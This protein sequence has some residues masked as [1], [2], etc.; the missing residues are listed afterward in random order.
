M[1]KLGK[2]MVVLLFMMMI[3][4]VASGCSHL[5]LDD[6]KPM[7]SNDVVL[8]LPRG[9]TMTLKEI[10]AGS[11]MMG[12]P[13]GEDGRSESE[14]LHKVTLEH[15]FWL[16]EFEVTQA[17]YKAVM[18]IN[19]SIFKG[20]DYP[21]DNVTWLD[22][23][24]FCRKLTDMERAAGRLPEGYRYSLPSEAQWEYACRAGTTTAWHYG[25]SLSSKQANFEGD[26][27]EGQAAVG[28][29]LQRPARVGSYA[30][31]AWGL[32]DMHGNVWEWCRD[33]ITDE[34]PKDPEFP[35]VAMSSGLFA[36]IRGG[37]WNC[38]ADVCRSARCYNSI[39]VSRNFNIGFRVA[40]VPER[41]VYVWEPSKKADEE[42]ENT[43][44]VAINSTTGKAEDVVLDLGG[45]SMRL[46]PVPKGSFT[47]T[48]LNKE[49]KLK[50]N[51]WLGE[52]EVTQEQYRAIMNE[53]NYSYFKRGGNFPV[54]NVSWWTAMTFCKKLT[55]RERAAGRLPDGYVYT[56]PT[57]AQWEHAARGGRNENY[58]YSGSNNLD[59]VGWY[60]EN[61]GKDRLD[62]SEWDAGKASQNK[63]S[64]YP[65]GRKMPN[66]L[67]LYDMNGNVYEWCRDRYDLY[68]RHDP[69]TLKGMIKY[70]FDYR[71]FRGGCWKED[72]MR[73]RTS[74]RDYCSS[75][76]FPLPNC[77]FRVALV[78]VQ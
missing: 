39:M 6:K 27:P 72:S 25:D 52:T 24:R 49:I 57:E 53:M 31:N 2:C 10:P 62:E 45:V 8:Q 63:G 19:R 33:L 37:G 64:I 42:S 41:T 22:A 11:F 44:S 56:L 68:W 30:P 55:E 3:M 75:I 74:F 20:S 51:Y 66:S 61:S 36:V 12:S 28:P 23:M 50:R 21:V 14:A 59:S 71:V 17:Q 76:H 48:H 77:G 4:G 46:K 78:P 35:T 38:T 47:N 1:K 32:Y 34:Y 7:I 67:G 26:I 43:E 9:I 18:G 60:Y 5:S 40:L 58:E 70:D 15:K 16:G 65:V 69:E 54:E 73:C 13:I 29:Y